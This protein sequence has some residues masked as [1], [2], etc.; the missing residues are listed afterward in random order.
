M[1]NTLDELAKILDWE[2]DEIKC[3]SKYMQLLRGKITIGS[4]EEADSDFNPFS[5]LLS[6]I[7]LNIITYD[8]GYL[9]RC[10]KNEADRSYT[11]ESELTYN[12]DF[13]QR[14]RLGRFNRKE[15]S[16][17]YCS[18]PNGNDLSNPTIVS[19]LE[20]CKD[21]IN[22]EL[23]FDSKDFTF[24][25]WEVKKPFHLVDLTFIREENNPFKKLVEE[26][27]NRINSVSKKEVSDIVFDFWE[28]I[29]QISCQPYNVD[30]QYSMS[31]LLFNAIKQCEYQGSIK[32]SGLRYPSSTTDRLG[33][34]VVL[35]PDVVDE[36]LKIDR[37]V[38][39][40]FLRNPLDK[41]S[42]D[43]VPICHV[44][45]VVDSTFK[46]K[47]WDEQTIRSVMKKSGI[48]NYKLYNF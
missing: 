8:C 23:K 38:E 44:E 43:I 48:Q 7:P 9:L 19:S 42:F 5:L 41:K 39:Y 31:N 13:K 10:S 22:A 4:Q 15:E 32:F 46:L 14:I 11:K 45:T 40:R 21:L 1:Q 28:F 36:C 35:L 25:T 33:T 3:L 24:S 29:S 6:K 18:V 17:F 27:I 20:C 47:R 2:D 12:K 37:V 16:M 30:F 26:N 34:N